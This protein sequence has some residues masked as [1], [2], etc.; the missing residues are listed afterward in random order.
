[1]VMKKSTATAFPVRKLS[2]YVGD[3]HFLK[4][5]ASDALGVLRHHP[6]PCAFAVS[7]LFFMGV[8]Y[9]LRMIPPMA[10]PF[11]L[12]FAATATLHRVLAARPALNTLLAGL[13]TVC[14][15]VI[16]L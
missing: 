5:T 14:V 7:L 9:T 16:R 3:A 6:M 12:G 13:N 2:G 1:M 8:E 15:F 4:W 11:D 10:P